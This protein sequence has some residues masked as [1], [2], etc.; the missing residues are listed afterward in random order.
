MNET[1]AKGMQMD[2]HNDDNVTGPGIGHNAPPDALELFLQGLEGRTRPLR[3]R[4]AEL[5][6]GCARVMPPQDEAEAGRIADFIAKQVRPALREW[7]AAKKAEKEPVAAMG[8]A[9]DA[10]FAREATALE[11]EAAAVVAYLTAYKA[12]QE[13]RAREEAARRRAE[14]EEARRVAAAQAEALRL[15]AEAKARAAEDE[16][17]RI[18][19]AQEAEVA[20]ARASEAEVLAKAATPEPPKVRGEYGAQL[21][22][23]RRKN[24]RV[25]DWDAIPREY[26]TVDPVNVK[27]AMREGREVPGIEFYEEE[28]HHVR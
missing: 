9:I 25:V 22:T 24:W 21:V 10:H 20:A 7:A 11:K 18:S 23:V 15:E 17:D 8:K 26:L 12:E 27:A 5:E 2:P 14:E 16:L 28:T 19:A 1:T 13:R 6:A 3:E 4:M